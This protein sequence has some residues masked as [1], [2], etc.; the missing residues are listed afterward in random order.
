MDYKE[1]LWKN[2]IRL[3]LFR[4][5]PN[6]LKDHNKLGAKTDYLDDQTKKNQVDG[7]SM[8]G[9]QETSIQSFGD[10]PE[11]NPWKT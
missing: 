7:T 11:K 5:A 3:Q 8:L 6:V 9:W 4:C 1:H 2:K 10:R